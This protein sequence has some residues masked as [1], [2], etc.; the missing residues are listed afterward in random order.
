MGLISGFGRPRWGV[1]V[2]YDMS[3]F[4]ERLPELL[5]GLS[6]SR[7]AEID[8]YPQGVECVLGF[9]PVGEDVC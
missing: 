9:F 1:D 3:A 4:V 7:F 6:E 2:G 8:L 5:T